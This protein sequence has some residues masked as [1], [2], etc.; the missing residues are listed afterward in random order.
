[1]FIQTFIELENRFKAETISETDL[2]MVLMSLYNR[3]NWQ[4]TLAF[5]PNTD[6]TKAIKRHNKILISI[7]KVEKL[8]DL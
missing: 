3:L 6:G 7:K 2:R 5:Q 4:K 8:L 1:M